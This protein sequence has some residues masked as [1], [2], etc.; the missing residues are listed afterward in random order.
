MLTECQALPFQRYAAATFFRPEY[1]NP[2]T[3]TLSGPAAEI[4]WGM[5]FVRSER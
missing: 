2:D 1:A 4:P 5:K 3:Q